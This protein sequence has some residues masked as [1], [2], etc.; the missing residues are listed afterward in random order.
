M[1]TD[2]ACGGNTFFTIS[3]TA[4]HFASLQLV[5]GNLVILIGHMFDVTDGGE[6]PYCNARSSTMFFL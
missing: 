6:C 1:R 5:S 3:A 4:R 2:L